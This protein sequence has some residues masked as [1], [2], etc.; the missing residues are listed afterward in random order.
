MENLNKKSN[1]EITMIYS[2]REDNY[3]EIRKKVESLMTE[4]GA[5]V[6]SNKDLGVKE[7]AYPILKNTH[8]HYYAYIINAPGVTIKKIVKEIRLM[9]DVLRYIIIHLD[10]KALRFFEKSEKKE[11]EKKPV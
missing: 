9:D 6:V 5:K 1:Y 2:S 4:L 10:K 7:F 11:K 8:G 3:Q